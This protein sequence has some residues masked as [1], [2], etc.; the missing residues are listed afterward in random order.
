MWLQFT[1]LYCLILIC[2]W[3]YQFPDWSKFLV[4]A[5]LYR[6]MRCD[7]M[8]CGAISGPLDQSAIERIM[9]LLDH[10]IDWPTH[11]WWSN[12]WLLKMRA[13]TQNFSFCNATIYLDNLV[14][15]PPALPIHVTKFVTQCGQFDWYVTIAWL[16][17]SGEL[18]PSYHVSPH[19]CSVLLNPCRLSVS[20]S[21]QVFVISLQSVSIGLTLFTAQ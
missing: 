6:Q 18:L 9:R 4:Y 10:R 11:E 5:C 2:C 15:P 13:K 21:Y 19:F 17:N 20:Y 14:Y 8:R 16:H 7:A 3:Q 1:C 12:P